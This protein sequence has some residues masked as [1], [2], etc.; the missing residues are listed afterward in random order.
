MAQLV[1]YDAND[2]VMY[3]HTLPNQAGSAN[4][5]HKS[6]ISLAAI[7]DGKKRDGSDDPTIL[8]PHCPTCGETSSI[9]LLGGEGA[10]RLHAHVR[11]ARGLYS[12]YLAA[13]Q[14]VINDVEAAGAV[15]RLDPQ[16]G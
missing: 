7:P 9:P 14:S 1:N 5:E 10:Q 13:V 12:T 6:M 8:A 2:Q 4:F 3:Y 15:P 11:F 16:V